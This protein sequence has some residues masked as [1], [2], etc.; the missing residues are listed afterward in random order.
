MAGS[1]LSLGL[2]SVAVDSIALDLT[3]FLALTTAGMGCDS[4]LD[5]RWTLCVS[6][7]HRPGCLQLIALEE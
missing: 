6:E 5:T 2:W 1:E 4:A 3:L 7:L